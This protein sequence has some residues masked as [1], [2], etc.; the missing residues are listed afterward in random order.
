M[1]VMSMYFSLLAPLLAQISGLCGAGKVWAKQQGWQGG[2]GSLKETRTGGMQMGI[3]GPAV[4]GQEVQNLPGSP[5]CQTFLS[6][7][8]RGE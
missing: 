8:R 1:R 5:S 3:L 7:P 2:D 4:G 6:P